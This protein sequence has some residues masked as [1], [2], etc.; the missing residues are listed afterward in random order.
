ML[1]FLFLLLISTG[2]MA[3]PLKVAIVSRTVFYVPLWIAQQQRYIDATIEVYNNAEKINEDLRSGK[4]NI[5]VGT[6]EA[7][8]IDAFKGGSLRIVGG[9]AE[10]LPHF[11]IARPQ[12][13]QWADMRGA[14][15][16]VLSLNEGTTYLVHRMMSANGFKPGD[17]EVLAVGG[18]PARWKLLQEGKIDAGLQP[19]PLSYQAEAAGFTNFGP[20]TQYVQ[21]YLFTTINV[22]AQ[23]AARNE[24]A[25]VAF[26]RGLRRGLETMN[27]DRGAAVAT[28]AKELNTTP[29]LAERALDDTAR[30]KILSQDLSVS[31]PALRGTFDTLVGVGLLPSDARFEPARMVDTRY[32]GR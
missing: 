29:A 24:Q 3:E 8:M 26:L 11:I 2:A 9:N 21:N 30:L 10:R 27:K 20:I 14:K 7:V 12:I 22:D 13:K 5:A 25:V 23:W 16:G 32:L 4:V 18:A 6:P 15:V 19:F 1:R 17:Y 28:A 31:H